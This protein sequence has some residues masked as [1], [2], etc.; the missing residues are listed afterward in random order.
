M[1]Q[2]QGRIF[3]SELVKIFACIF[4]PVKPEVKLALQP[5]CIL[6]TTAQVCGIYRSNQETTN[7]QNKQ[8]HFNI[9]TFFFK[10]IACSW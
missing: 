8:F 7:T 4:L 3:S 6:K 10:L 1:L 9:C 5:L 2:K